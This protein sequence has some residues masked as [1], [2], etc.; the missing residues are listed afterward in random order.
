MKRFR[1]WLETIKVSHSVFALPFALMG[2]FLAD[3]GPPG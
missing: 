1:L 2:A 3:G